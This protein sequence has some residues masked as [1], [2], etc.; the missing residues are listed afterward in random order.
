MGRARRSAVRKYHD[1]VAPIYD[2]SYDDAFWQWHDALTWDYLK[3]YLP[4]TSRA[5]V[6][7]L[8]CGTGKWALRLL[9][10][11]YVVTCL[12]VSPRMLEQA[13]KRIENEGDR[14][15]ARF[16]QADLIDLSD[17]PAGR[18]ELAVALGDPIGCCDSPRE[19]MKQIRRILTPNGVLVASF[20]NKLAAV[21][22]YVER[23]DARALSRFL[24]EGRTHWLTRDRSERFP[25]HT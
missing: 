15:R 10:S 1:R 8:G 24:R 23:G 16:V 13:R 11:G 5:E 18:F 12:D 2:H 14:D 19:A 20:D 17:L 4:R 9:K 21:E 7:D 22:Y 6:I 25:I 3:P